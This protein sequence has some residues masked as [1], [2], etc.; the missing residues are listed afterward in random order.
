MFDIK[1]QLKLLPDKPG[2]YI[3]K[4][5]FETVI[6][7]GKAINLK[8][9]VRQYFRTSTNHSSK[10]KAMV[11]NV[12]S[13]EYIITD[14]EL[15]ALIL[16]CNLI[17]KYRP[18]Y[19]ILLRDD[20][21]YPYIKVTTNEDFP[22][23]LKVRRII[24][25]KAKYFGPYTNIAAVNDTLNIITK[26]Y[27]I[28][29]CNLDMA[30]A[31]RTHMR[32]CLEYYIHNCVG[33][34]TGNVTPKEYDIHVQ[35]IIAF[36][37]GK[38][39]EVV[40]ILKEN[41]LKAASLEKFEEAADYRDKL[42]SIEDTLTAQK[43]TN[44]TNND[45]R[46]ILAVATNG[47]VACVESFFVRNGRLVGRENFI[48]EGV[49][50]ENIASILTN[51]ITQFYGEQKYIPQEILVEK[52]L[53]D[54]ENI[55]KYLSNKAGYVIK[56]KE[57]KR[58]EKL[59]MIELVKKNAV[60]YLNKFVEPK[61][62]MQKRT[63]E[64]LEDLRVILGIDE[65][66]RRIEAYDISNI[67]GTDSVG[68]MVVFTNGRK[69]RHEY[70]RYRIK[71]VIGA[72]DVA[73]MAEVVERRLKYGNYPNLILLDGARNQVNA[74]QE[75]LN[76]LNIDIELWGMYKD[77][78]HRTEGLINQECEFKLDRSTRLYKFIAGIQEEVHN[79]AITYHRSLRE[80]KMT[81]S[82]LDDIKGVGKAKRKALLDKFKTIENIRQAS[83]SQ[84]S[85]IKG[86]NENL[87]R[88]IKEFLD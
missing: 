13:F 84:L 51:F 78:K 44:A 65:A 24:N 58:G 85:E 70:R 37:S 45:N 60:E 40:N 54:N 72:N 17:K 3:M 66:P 43:I 19:N 36:L 16:E 71:T 48:L 47:V 20:K 6:Y 22:R 46:D 32:P 26:V 75:V 62:E 1:R 25:D 79:Y 38:S 88:R 59:S 14:N 82:A 63:D 86:V 87:A 33:P 10:V 83:V 7:V 5:A 73:S 34:C 30:R 9:R 67:Q 77:D 35:K 55:E 4:D 56:I 31:I 68:A 69:D 50:E 21:T 27:P 52:Q 42:K 29:T 74:V 57:P 49:D 53:L 39:K 11:R 8:N 41:M 28:R 80:A 12:T 23:V 2:V 61:K 81:H 76:R 18:R 15:E 64:V